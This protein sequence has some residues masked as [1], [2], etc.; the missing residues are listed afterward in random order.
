MDLCLW[1]Q[2]EASARTHP[3]TGMEAGAC[4]QPAHHNVCHKVVHIAI[5]YSPQCFPPLFVWITEA[6]NKSSNLSVFPSTNLCQQKNV[7]LSKKLMSV[8]ESLNRSHLYVVF[9]LMQIHALG[10]IVISYNSRLLVHVCS[11]YWH[12]GLIVICSQDR[13]PLTL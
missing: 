7:F 5:K 1:A 11:V 10:L 9:V 8:F 4:L 3:A 2:A 12:P 6:A 13:R